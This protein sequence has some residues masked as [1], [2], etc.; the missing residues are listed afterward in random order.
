MSIGGGAEGDAACCKRR[1]GDMCGVLVIDVEVDVVAIGYNGQ[2]VR[3]AQLAADVG[4]EALDQRAA[5][6]A[7]DA[8]QP[9]G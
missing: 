1:I 2:Q 4:I 6:P 9:I 5:F 7:R 8:L 3:L